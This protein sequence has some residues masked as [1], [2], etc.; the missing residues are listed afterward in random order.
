MTKYFGIQTKVKMNGIF[1]GVFEK[2]MFKMS[3][4]ISRKNTDS[5]DS[6]ILK[7]TYILSHITPIVLMLKN[8][9]FLSF[10]DVIISQNKN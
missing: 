1:M 9:I 10:T 4:Y 5:G 7:E 3:D 6:Y 8:N 2:I